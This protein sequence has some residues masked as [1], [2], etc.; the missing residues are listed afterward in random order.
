MSFYKKSL[1]ATF[2]AMAFSA[3][4]LG[5][6]EDNHAEIFKYALMQE[7]A[8]ISLSQGFCSASCQGDLLELTHAISQSLTDYRRNDRKRDQQDP[9]NEIDDSTIP[10]RSYLVS[11]PIDHPHLSAYHIQI[12]SLG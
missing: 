3:A 8:T 2:G 12:E 1:M 4:I 6:V 11:A 5:P 10:G 9:A 7:E